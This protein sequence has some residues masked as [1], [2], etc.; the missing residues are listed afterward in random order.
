MVEVNLNLMHYKFI[1]MEAEQGFKFPPPCMI[2]IKFYV[3]I[4]YKSN[5]VPFLLRSLKVSIFTVHTNITEIWYLKGQQL[6][7]CMLSNLVD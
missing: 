2:E 6:W 5:C 1:A 4:F 7:I 3:D